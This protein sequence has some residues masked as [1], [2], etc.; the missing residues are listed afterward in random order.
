MFFIL[1]GKPYCLQNSGLSSVKLCLFVVQNCRDKN[2]K[3]GIRVVRAAEAQSRDNA[4]AAMAGRDLMEK[5]GL[6]LRVER[7]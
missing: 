2:T 7:K 3:Q 6:R 4:K 1:I 5:R